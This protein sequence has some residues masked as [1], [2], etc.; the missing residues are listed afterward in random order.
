MEIKISFPGGKKV[1]AELGEFTIA[2]DQPRSMGG[3]GTAPSPYALFLAS[4]G[5]CAGI[6]VLSF[7]HE[8]GIPTD[9]VFLVQKHQYTT[10][11]T[12][13]PRLS[14]IKIEIHLPPDFPEKYHKAIIRVADQCA[15]KKTILNPPPMEV[16]TVVD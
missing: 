5:T 1:H 9:G 8:R 2:T 16:L 11:E 13:T 14:A 10:S 4:I 7:C 15:V 6:Y 3:D 12:G